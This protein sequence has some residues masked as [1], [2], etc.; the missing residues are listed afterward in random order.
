MLRAIRSVPP[1]ELLLGKR[2]AINA[3]PGEKRARS[4]P[5]IIR[6]ALVGKKVMITMSRITRIFRS[7]SSFSLIFIIIVSGQ[8]AFNRMRRHTSGKVKISDV[9]I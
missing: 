4:N 3:Y 8:L 2:A 1:R 7:R 5:K 9:I 6:Q